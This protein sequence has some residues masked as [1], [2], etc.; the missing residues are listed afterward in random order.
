MKIFY[1]VVTGSSICAVTE[2]VPLPG[3]QVG[4]GVGSETRRQIVFT[5]SEDGSCQT[6]VGVV[7]LRFSNESPPQQFRPEIASCIMHHTRGVR[8]NR[9][10]TPTE[11][12]H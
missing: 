8:N 11:G 9:V 3:V 1:G 12:L 5:V 2:P 6:Q 7:S 10:L 4:G